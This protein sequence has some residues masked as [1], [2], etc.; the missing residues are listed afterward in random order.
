MISVEGGVCAFCREG[1]QTTDEEDIE[2]IKKR[3][4]LDDHEAFNTMGCHYHEG[5][6]NL[7]PQ[8]H[9]KAR[10]MWYKAANLGSILAHR[11]IA[12][13]YAEGEGVEKDN[14][15]AI[16]HWN[17]AAMGGHEVCRHNL[18]VMEEQKGNLKTRAIRHY[19]LAA[20]AG[21]EDALYQVKRGYMNGYATKDEFENTL[22]AYHKS[23]DE[24][25]SERRDKAEAYR[26]HEK[27]Y[28]AANN[29][30]NI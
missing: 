11:N 28:Y 5:F 29:A 15:K 7:I 12:A 25:K 10:E 18:G 2:R 1:A 26:A 13:R 16:Y 19:I 20:R 23:L 6:L 17:F 21:Y 30:S 27:A 14:K 9:A 22:R 8:D 24:V 4:E 3:M